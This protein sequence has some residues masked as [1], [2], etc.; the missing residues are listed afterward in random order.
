MSDNRWLMLLFF[1]FLCYSAAVLGSIWTSSSVGAWYPELRK[2]SFNPPN[3]IFAPVWSVLYFL[4]ALSA[5]LV[6]RKADWGGTRLAL[7]LFFVQLALNVAWSWLFFGLRRPGI[8]LVEIVFLFGAVVATG[9]AFQPVSGF[10]F[11]LMVPYALWV[12]FA[13]LLNFKIWRLNLGA[14]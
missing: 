5:W 10:A 1:L 14:T 2:P 7:T 6:W 12:A 11:W 13:S 8:A 3:W 4:M 9:W